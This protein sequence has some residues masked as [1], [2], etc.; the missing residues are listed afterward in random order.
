MKL[1]N[2]ESRTV[3]FKREF[4][5]Q[6]VRTVIAFANSFGGRIFIGVEDDGTVCGVGQVDE[7][8]KQVL[9]SVRD[10]VSPDIMMFV[11]C[12]VLELEGKSVLSLNVLR[13]TKRPYY[14]KGKGPNPSGT[15]VRQG[16]ETVPASE[17]AIL[18]MILES[19]GENYE[20]GVSLEQKLTFYEL[21]DFFR[22]A[23]RTLGAEEMRQFRLVVDDA[24]TNLGFWLSDQYDGSIKIAVFEGAEMDAVKVRKET[25]GSLLRQLNEAFEFL[26][27]KGT[28]V[29]SEKMQNL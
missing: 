11:D 2:H 6:I 3:E 29:N 5:P 24:F 4:T 23:H 19:A 8:M 1:A 20:T 26:R 9:N 22:A 18:K 13:G 17:D 21:G 12:E 14:L 28:S 15:F 16:A 25:S 7:V 27:L 10:A